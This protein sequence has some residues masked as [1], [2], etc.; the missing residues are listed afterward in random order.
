MRKLL[1]FLT[2]WA[3]SGLMA[4]VATAQFTESTGPITT[5]S[6]SI[7]G[8]A[9]EVSFITSTGPEV[10]Q[11]TI[12]CQTDGGA[13]GMFSDVDRAATA[14]NAAEW[15]AANFLIGPFGVGSSSINYTTPNYSGSARRFAIYLEPANT[16]GTFPNDVTVT[17]SNAGSAAS[18]GIVVQPQVNILQ[19]TG[20]GTSAGSNGTVTVATSSVFPWYTSMIAD[21]ADEVQ[22]E[23]DVDFGG[24]ATTV[25]RNVGL[26]GTA[27]AH[28]N[29]PPLG[30]GDLIFELYDVT[31]D[32][33]ASPSLSLTVPSVGGSPFGGGED[34]DTYAVPA[35]RSGI[36]TFRVIIRAAAGMTPNLLA[37]FGVSFDG[38]LSLQPLT[39]TPATATER[40]SISPAGSTLTTSP[41]TLTASG[42]TPTTTYNWSLQ[43]T[44]P[45]GVSLSGTS[46]ATVDLI[47]GSSTPASSTVIVRVENGATGEFVE[48]TYTLNFS[49]GGGG[50]MITGP[51]SLPNGSEGVVYTSTTVTA[52]GGTPAY[53]WGATGLPAGL[54][55]N[56]TTGEISGT[57]NAG[58]AAGSPYA[59][60]VTVTDTAAGNDSQNYT[61]DISAAGT[62]IITTGQNLTGGT[63]GQAYSANISAANG[64]GAHTW[65]VVAGALPAGVT[66]GA[67]ATATV[68]ISG[69]PTANGTFNFTIEVTDSTTPTAQT[70]TQAFTLVI[71]AAGGGGGGGLGGGGGG[72]GGCVADSG[73]SH[74]L[75]LVGLLAALG[76]VGTLRTRKE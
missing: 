72:G 59:V 51:S 27:F 20:L 43:G 55:I 74:W 76:V 4:T 5:Q 44:V 58:T 29:F 40:I 17:L 50:L 41:Q 39:F 65:A 60:T 14:T 54:S 48:E 24:T 71:A 11:L 62:L 10:L 73:S 68:A 35:G 67:S 57:P 70:D 37:F 45:T 28:A 13:V 34:A 64:T 49:G 3:V 6:N 32:G 22:F 2:I 42:G 69:T 21:A 36:H 66:L 31:A 56:T 52:T 1:T 12:D 9:F 61:I 18:L 30:T 38:V 16:A 23:F 47:F 63:E 26:Y 8:L 19:G 33:F 25:T 7:I 53:T 75:V 15:N 46:G